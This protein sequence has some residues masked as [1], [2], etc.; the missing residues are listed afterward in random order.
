MKARRRILRTNM[1]TAEVVLWLKL[2]NKQMHGKRFLRQY[3]ID[4]YVLDFY[5][6]RLRLAIEVDGDSHSKMNVEEYDKARQD[7][8]ESFGIQFLRFTNDDV[9]KNIDGVCKIIYNEIDKLI[10][11]KDLTDFQHLMI[12]TPFNSPLSTVCTPPFKKGEARSA[13]DWNI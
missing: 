12:I 5:C 1:S 2:K 4:Q 6:P 10:L 9:R 11:K 13:G 8:I 3:S 7:Y